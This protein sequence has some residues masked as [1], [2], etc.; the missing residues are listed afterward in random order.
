MSPSRWLIAGGAALALA[1]TAPFAGAA[2]TKTLKAT[3]SG[4]TEVPKGDPDGKGNATIRIKGSQ[5]CYTFA[6]S[7]IDTPNAAHIHEG[8]KGK[9]GPVVVP[10]F[11]KAHKK[12]GCVTVK[13]SVAKGI[14]AKPGE[15]YVNLHNA[16]Y[17]GGALRGQLHK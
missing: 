6:Y 4:S 2:A 17:P 16:K 10:F 8:A 15:Y 14:A 12:T 11:N 9:A 13:S 3:L 5:V 7:K 1:A